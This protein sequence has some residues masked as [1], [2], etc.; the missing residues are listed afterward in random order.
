MR[1]LSAAARP[2]TL[3]L[4]RIAD[5]LLAEREQILQANAQDI[6]AARAPRTQRI[7]YRPAGSG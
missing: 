7:F 1:W 2:K 5:V 3:P 6:A 4:A